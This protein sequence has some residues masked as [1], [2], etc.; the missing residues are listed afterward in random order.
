MQHIGFDII[1]NNVHHVNDQ[2]RKASG[3]RKPS[4][5][6]RRSPGT[7]RKAP[8]ARQSPWR[9]AQ[10]SR[11]APEDIFRPNFETIQ[12]HYVKPCVWKLFWPIVPGHR[13]WRPS[14]GSGELR[15]ALGGLQKV[16]GGLRRALGGLRTASGELR[17][18]PGGR[19]R[20]PGGLRRASERLRKAISFVF[21]R[22]GRL[23]ISPLLFFCLGWSSAD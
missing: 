6:F 18:V 16:F 1:M 14:E 3:D 10:S 7:L 22:G 21:F 11:K 19:Q 20:G 17:K 13:F 5:G 8:G 23:R 4:G 9:A 12:I 2:R 15:R